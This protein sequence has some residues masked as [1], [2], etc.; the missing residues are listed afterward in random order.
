MDNYI[1]ISN[2]IIDYYNQNKNETGTKLNGN[3]YRIK[4][5]ETEIPPYVDLKYYFNN[6]KIVNILSTFCKNKSE[7]NP[8]IYS[9]EIFYLK[10]IQFLIL[11]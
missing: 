7:I 1:A 11:I 10:K 9:S 5:N 3:L 4:F 8:Q 2:E 6:S